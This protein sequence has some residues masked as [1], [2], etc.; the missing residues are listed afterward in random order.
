MKIA[1]RNPDRAA[2]KLR[3]HHRYENERAPKMLRGAE[4]AG[5][6]VLSFITPDVQGQGWRMPSAPK[7]V[8]VLG[9]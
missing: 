6:R 1:L 7:K 5:R 2:P 8:P 3:R 9:S 4:G